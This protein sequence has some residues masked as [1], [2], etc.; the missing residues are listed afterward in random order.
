M[1][2]WTEPGAQNFR[3][4]LA[5]CSLTFICFKALQTWGPSVFDPQSPVGLTIVIA[6]Y[7]W[8]SAEYDATKF[9]CAGEKN[10]INSVQISNK[11]STITSTIVL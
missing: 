10:S 2:L 6:P 5:S 7:I 9:K 3:I 11:V 1:I 4:S 8:T